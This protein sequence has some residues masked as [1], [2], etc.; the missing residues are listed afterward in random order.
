LLNSAAAYQLELSKQHIIFGRSLPLVGEKGIVQNVR[1]WTG[2]WLHNGLD[3][4]LQEFK[5]LFSSK[6]ISLHAMLLARNTHHLYRFLEQIVSHVQ[7]FGSNNIAM[8]VNCNNNACFVN[9]QT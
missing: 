5:L 3:F 7:L 4:Q 6:I 2:F 1:L 8:T 9:S